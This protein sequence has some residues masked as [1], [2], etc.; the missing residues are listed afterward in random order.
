MSMSE[1]W[2]GLGNAVLAF[3]TENLS[4]TLKA[5]KAA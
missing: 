5:F 1:A 3:G 2:S 4:R